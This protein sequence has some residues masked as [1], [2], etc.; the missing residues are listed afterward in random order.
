M[1]RFHVK[2]DLVRMFFTQCFDIYGSGYENTF[3]VS[4]FFKDV[5]N[6]G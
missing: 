2:K 6:F 1:K 3:K 5:A 4:A